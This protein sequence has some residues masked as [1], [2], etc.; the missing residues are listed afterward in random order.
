MNHSTA[1]LSEVARH[2]IAPAGI[3]VTAWP[4]VRATCEAMGLTFDAWQDDLG[5]LITA[6]N[7][8]GT[9]AADMFAMSIPRQT[10]KTYLLGALVFAMC[11]KLPN[12]T[13][14]WTAHR[15]RTAAETFK[16][17]QAL[18]RRDKIAP[19]VAKVSLARGE[20]SVNFTNGSRILFGARERGFGR[21]FA[22]VDILLF[23]E[24]QILSESA[25]DDM[26]PA[27]NASPNPLILFAGTP[28]KPTDPGE[29]FTMLR[30]DAMSG[31]VQEV[32]YVEIS[33]ERGADLDDRTQWRRMN[34]SYPH[35]T[36]ERAIL[37]MRKALSDDSF[38]REAM[39]IWDEFSLHQPVIKAAQW[40]E[41][42]DVGPNISVKP[43]AIAV[44]MSHGRDISIAAAWAEENSTHIEEVWSGTD[45]V[46]A[47]DWITARAGRRTTVMVDSIGPASSLVPDLR[48][49]KCKVRV[50]T[51]ADMS[52]ACGLFEN[53]VKSQTVTHADQETLTDAL[54]HARKRP[55]RDAGGWGWDRSDAHKDIHPL[56]AAT[57]ALL[58][59]AENKRGVRA[60]SGATFV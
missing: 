1:P 58:G 34:P 5:K 26:V 57:L 49:R 41:L 17:M 22:G 48:T 13:A 44:D 15:T 28:P 16:G 2:V 6:K 27:T 36:S 14:I 39:G 56:V 38:Q 43:D 21:G 40:A 8:T 10:G 50:T 24:A 32:G 4:S 20:E 45:P 31:D 55:I 47:L 23:D 18:A 37:R 25:M 53:S 11:V 33:A 52:R 30:A 19:H 3:T 51:A 35:R 46:A 59:A 7:A 29:V 42:I 9:Y 12:L 54:L 60:T